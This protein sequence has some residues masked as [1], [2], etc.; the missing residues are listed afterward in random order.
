MNEKQYSMKLAQACPY[1][2]AMHAE[3]SFTRAAERLGVH[4]TAVSHRIRDLEAMLGYSLFERTTRSLRFTPAGEAL[5]AAA[6]LAVDQM[7]GA[8]RRVEAM[9]RSSAVR[10]SASSSLA[11]KWLLPLLGDARED[12]LDFAV[13]VQEDAVDLRAGEAEVAIRFGVGPYP[14]LYAERLTTCV[15][16]PVASPRLSGIGEL[17]KNPD[18]RGSAPLIA[19][20]RGENDGTGFSWTAHAALHGADP[21]RN[22]P[23]HAFDRAD[24]ALQAAIDGL[25]VA[26]GRTL[27]I[28]RDIA[29]G[30][31]VPI[32]EPAPMR[33]SYWLV[34]PHD[35]ER[36]PGVSALFDW[37]RDK[38]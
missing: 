20:R 2:A 30:L 6:R 15:M 3:R 7:D 8:R 1:L 4:Q 29:N 17:L 21:P 12:G 26:L 31:L 11:M 14:G 38:V 24:L 35:A 9:R 13:L 5:C 34:S 19:D 37:L 36:P 28:E 25:G 32:G 33:A 16:Q 18:W 22:A 23:I 10:I 27:L